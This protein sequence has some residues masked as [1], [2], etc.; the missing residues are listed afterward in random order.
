M[1]LQ[2][3]MKLDLE[4]VQEACN[5]RNKDV[6]FIGNLSDK[7]VVATLAKIGC[8]A[9]GT[10]SQES[11]KGLRD[12]ITDSKE[13][14]DL[15]RRILIHEAQLAVA[16]K[17]SK[18]IVLTMLGYEKFYDDIAR[19][20]K[21]PVLKLSDGIVKKFTDETCCPNRRLGLI[22]SGFDLNPG[23]REQLTQRCKNLNLIMPDSEGLNKMTRAIVRYVTLNGKNFEYEMAQ[24]CQEQIK[25]MVEADKPPDCILLCNIELNKTLIHLRSSYA[26]KIKIISMFDMF[27]EMIIAFQP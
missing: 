2:K 17:E 10:E 11:K 5:F 3:T 23:L 16:E 13:H 1:S 19:A 24:L 20:V 12:L 26:D 8:C 6:C 22:G 21:V 4:S 14:E 9:Y 18:A 7:A 25:A 27:R 15:I